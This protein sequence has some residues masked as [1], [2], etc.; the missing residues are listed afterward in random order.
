MKSLK[1]LVIAGI[2]ISSSLFAIGGIGIYGGQGMLT[3]AST[4]NSEGLATVVT[5]EFSNPYQVGLYLYIDAIPFVDFEAD[6]QVTGSE[7]QFSFVNPLGEVGPFDAIWGG[8]STY[9]TLRKK[10][11]GFEIPILGGANLHGGAGFNMH[12]FAPLANMDLAESIMGDLTDEPVF[13]EDDL[14]DFSKDNKIDVNG[15]HIQGGFQFKLLMLDTFLIYR[16][17]FGDFEDVIDEGS[18]GSLNLRVGIGI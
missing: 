16:H 3:V 13:S 4:D 8:V 1:L 15:F 2:L 10:I 14:I 12:S 6:I 9:F 17:N 11:V 18:F 7:Y 5:D